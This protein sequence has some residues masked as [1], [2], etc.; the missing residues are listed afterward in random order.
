MKQLDPV[1]RPSSTV[2]AADLKHQ[3]QVIR[4]SDAWVFAAALAIMFMA[5][6]EATI[7]AAAMPA[8]VA[9]L[10]GFDHFTWVFSAYLL[11][12][13]VAIP[14]YGRLADIHG[15]KAILLVGIG[16]F[17][18]GSLLA[19][20]AWDML[21]LIVFRVIQGMGAGAL[22]PVAQTVVGD[23]YS[24]ERR[25]RMQGYVSSIF[26]SAAVLGP[27]I[28][29]VLIAYA[30]WPL[31]FWINIPLGF[32]ASL[33]LIFT[34]REPARTHQHSIDLIGAALMMFGTGALMFVLIQAPE[35]S[36]MTIVL[37]LVA[38][39]MSFCA[40]LLY[41]RR[42]PEPM[43]PL[44]IYRNRVIVGGNTVCLAN[45][46]IMM[47][48]VAFL[49]AYMQG[50]MQSGPALAS[51]ALIAMSL[52]WPIGGFVGSRLVLWA[53]FRL[54]ALIGSIILV[55][56]SATMIVLNPSFGT[57]W[58][59]GGAT[60]LGFGMGITNICFVVA[61]QG[62]VDRTERA[63]ATASMAF[64]RIVGQSLGT[65]VFGSILN[66]GLSGQGKDAV[67][68]LMQPELHLGTKAESLA[69]VREAFAA[70]LHHIHLLAGVLVLLVLAAVR[71]LPVRSN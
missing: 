54:A 66:V 31:V 14:I 57:L 51:T 50:V 41:E 70:S 71:W 69:A 53:T 60:F 24:G 22:I 46:A 21:S 40:L 36:R 56:G 37:L 15:R 67:L 18:C 33:M 27:T 26:G 61:V 65:A 64:S 63:S 42:S 17:L 1:A 59:I 28:G 19:G 34:L 8:I 32:L 38:S 29:T 62:T 7:V 45:G 9:Q 58:P 20:F 68:R 44:K 39:T 2:T 11:T 35:L 5:A 13:A 16:I 47:S 12:Q 43:L 23:L 6:V 10:G 30:S 49:P 3:T 52:A 48:I 25:A 4:N 55:I